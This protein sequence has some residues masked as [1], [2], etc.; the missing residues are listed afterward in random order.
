MGKKHQKKWIVLGLLLL[1]IGGIVLYFNN[2]ENE[3]VPIVSA[4]LLPGLRDASDIEI[5]KRAQEIADAN[6]FTLQIAPFA[7]FENGESEGSIEI[8]NPGTNV[9]PI[10]VD[11]TL[12]ETGEV[13]Y[14]SGAI[15]PNQQIV[16]A[17]LD[18]SLEK[19]EYQGIARINIY[20]PETNE[21]QGITEAEISITIQN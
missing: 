6:Y 12:A 14:S 4:D 1:I 16:G 8:V 18:K 2:Q 21:R 15:Y 17:K 9:Y 19:G 5:A 13:I 20:D 3:P 7:V 10:A 11:L